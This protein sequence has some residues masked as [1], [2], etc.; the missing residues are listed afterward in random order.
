VSPFSQSGLSPRAWGRPLKSRASDPV[1]IEVRLRHKYTYA[2]LDMHYTGSALSRP[3][4]DRVYEYWW[5]HAQLH[6]RGTWFIGGPKYFSM[7]V[8]CDPHELFKLLSFTAKRLNWATQQIAAHG[9]EA[10]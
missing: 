10:L 5:T 9:R 6:R 1:L 8:I 2:S 4:F 3:A 7:K